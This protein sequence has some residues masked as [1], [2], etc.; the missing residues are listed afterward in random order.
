MQKSIFVSGCPRLR[1]A[2]GALAVVLLGG[3]L[4]GVGVAAEAPAPEAPAADSDAAPAEAGG[5]LEEVVVTAQKREQSEQVVPVSI[6]ALSGDAL[7]QQVVLDL[8][9]LMAHVTG[10][11]I[12]PNAQGDAATFAIRSSKQDNGTTGGVA[13]YLDD[14]PLTSTYS[15]ANANYDIASVDVLKGPQGTLFGTSATGGAII[16]RPN[17][18]AQDFDA[19]VWAQYGDYRRSEITGMINVPV[20]DILQV[21]LAADYV[22]RPD[23]FV[24]N[25]A[26]NP[27]AGLPSELW[28]DRHDSARLSVRLITGAVTHDVVADYYSENDTPSQ[29][30][31]TELTPGVASL[32]V[33]LL[34]GYNQVALGGNASGI[35]LPVYRRITSW[36]VKDTSTWTI[37]DN[38]SFVN[39]IGYRNDLQ[40]TFQSSSSEV[41]DMV[42]GRT[43]IK[44]LSGVE[45]A[46]LHFDMGP[47]HNTT[48]LFL[49]EIHEDDGNSYDL[50][51]NYTYTIDI[52]A[53]AFGAGTPAIV[54][55]L[56]QLSNAYYNRTL[57]SVAPYS[58]TEFKLSN[59]LTLIAG[60]RYNWDGGT[61]NDTQHGGTPPANFFEPQPNGNFFYGPCDPSVIQAYP[62][63]NAATC[64]AS[65]SASWKAPSWNLAL[66]DQFADHKMVYFRVAHGY[67]AGGFNN[68]ISDTRYQIFQPEKTTEF[69]AG[70]K[71]DWDVGGRPLR[72]NFALFDGD[73]SN[74]QEVENGSTCADQP[75][76]TAAQC[77]AFYS[78]TNVTS[79]WIGVFNAGSLNY[80]GFDLALEY[81][82]V[83]WLQ[84]NAGWSFIEASYTSF[85][86]PTVGEIPTQDLSGSTP[87]QVPKNTLTA[88]ATLTW[89]IPS[90]IGRVSSTLSAYYRSQTNFSDIFNACNTSTNECLSPNANTAPAYATFDFSTFWNGLLGSHIDLTAYVKNLADRRYIVYQSPQA[91]LGYA[92]TSFGE[93]RTFGM[94]IRYNFR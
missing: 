59:E 34:N 70:L 25:L 32:G 20:N 43:R 56:A 22:D 53:G 51:Q 21:R 11:V 61:F 89:P 81:L 64:T 24:K 86:F 19:W 58:Q 16:F 17:K 15:V 68:Q 5:S 39:N 40:D 44:H 33:P 63:Y 54:A 65:N 85:A 91:S 7:T 55:P 6:T 88:S 49:N 26:P 57:H 60:V 50:A 83:D 31:L 94:G 69:E 37:N 45:E 42:N 47:V 66:Q 12:A 4:P 1:T 75:N 82:P 76:L 90:N 36:G 71:A 62:R 78:G 92:T 29:S 27:S 38:L 30:I 18:P 84:L 8:R 9:D 72:T 80:Y 93:P 74:K 28:T 79:Q 67:I 23:G 48:G 46:T 77:T 41:I 10:L 2:G 87:A 13:V 3:L 35:D 14:M 52:P 73:V